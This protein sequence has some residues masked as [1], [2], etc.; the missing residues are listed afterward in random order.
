MQK[1][2]RYKRLC[3][4]KK[5]NLILKIIKKCLKTYQIENITYLEKQETAVDCFKKDKKDFIKN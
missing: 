2:K 4:K 3:H 1:S 5:L